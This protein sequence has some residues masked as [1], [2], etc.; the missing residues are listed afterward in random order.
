[1]SSRDETA[2]DR[3]WRLVLGGAAEPPGEL[4]GVPES[5]LSGTDRDMDRVLQALYESDRKSGLGSSSPH[6]NR[7]LGDIRRF[8]PASV[9]RVLQRDALER[10]R[11][12]RMLLEPETLA[13]V[14]PDI[15]LAATLLTLKQV[16]P[17][18]TRETARQVVRR[19]VEQ[20]ERRLRDRLMAAVKGALDRVARTS[21]PRP[22]EVDW[23]RTIRKNLRHYLPEQRTIVPERL[24]GHGRRQSSLRDVVLCV[25]QSG[26]MATSTVYA[27]IF[28]AVLASLRA[29]RTRLVVF[30]TAVVDLTDQ[31]DDPVDVLFGTQLGGGTDIAQALAYCQQRIERPAQTVLVLI[32]DLFEGGD[33]EALLRRGAELTAAG[34]T[35]ICLLALNDDGAP[36]YHEGLARSLAALEIPC[37]ACTP[38]L[39]PDLLAA[40]LARQDV[41]S[42][43]ERQGLVVRGEAELA[44]E[45]VEPYSG[46]EMG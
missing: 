15:H 42:W 13:A 1:M 8:F 18:Q 34:A 30:D 4:G 21:R 35:V 45:P 43:A 16:I 11:L 12:H 26:S 10:L 2:L 44:R 39:F 24:V 14:E 25:D 20:V 5:G 32:T 17:E 27:G 33:S 31:L 7:W 23:D 29:V 3:R 19:V 36:A 6:V 41:K 37:F 22:Q 28:A 38:D 9:V 40:A 46:F